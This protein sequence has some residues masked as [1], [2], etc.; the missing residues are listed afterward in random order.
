[1]SLLLAHVL[2]PA[3]T[4]LIF[5]VAGKGHDQDPEVIPYHLMSFPGVGGRETYEEKGSLLGCCSTVE[6]AVY[7]FFL[8]E[9]IHLFLVPSIVSI[10][11]ITVIFPSLV[12]AHKKLFLSHPMVF[13]F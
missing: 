5:A 7:C 4:E 13:T 8:Y 9:I 10:V 1:M 3:R 11:A 2:V 12:A 6:T